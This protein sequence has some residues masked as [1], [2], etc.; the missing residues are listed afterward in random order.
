[1]PYY[2]YKH[3]RYTLKTVSSTNLFSERWCSGSSWCSW[4][5]IGGEVLC[6]GVWGFAISRYYTGCWRWQSGGDRDEPHRS[7]PILLADDWRQV[8]LWERWNNN[9]ASKWTKICHKA[10]SATSRRH[11][12][13]SCSQTRTRWP[14]KEVYLTYVFMYFCI[15]PRMQFNRFCLL[16]KLELLV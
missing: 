12:E 3:Y 1:M 14:R 5:V 15:S 9:V 7:K 8:F 16:L 13:S 11:L 10:P 4:R 6:S 2:K